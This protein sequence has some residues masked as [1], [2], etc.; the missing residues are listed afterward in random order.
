MAGR[1]SK[2]TDEIVELIAD[3][4]ALGMTIKHTCMRAGINPGTYHNWYN[5]GREGD[6]RYV[7]YFNKINEAVGDGVAENLLALKMHGLKDWRATAKHLAIIDVAYSERARQVVTVA[8]GEGKGE[9]VD[10]EGC[11]VDEL[12]EL[13]ETILA[14]VQ[15]QRDRRE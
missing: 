3:S 11:T 1:E 8:E 12:K 7:E 6:P 10:F 4:R 13:R 9:R 5:A 15:E 14:K 2:I